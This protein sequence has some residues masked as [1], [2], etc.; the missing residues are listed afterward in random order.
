MKV[1]ELLLAA[2]RAIAE[3]DVT[4]DGTFDLCVRE[5]IIFCVPTMHLTPTDKFVCSLSK[6]DVTNG[7]NNSQWDR[8]FRNLHVEWMNGRLK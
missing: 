7:L 1:S 8:I 2:E 5:G 6:S 3:H 4:H